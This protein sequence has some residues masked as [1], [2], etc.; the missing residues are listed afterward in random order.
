MQF[1]R[2]IYKTPPGTHEGALVKLKRKFKEWWL[3]PVIYRELTRGGDNTALKQWAANHLW[4]AQR[5]GG[6]PLHGV[7]LTSRVVF[8]KEAKDLSIAEQFVLAS[9]VNKPDHPAGRQRAA[10]RG[11]ARPLALHHRG[12]RAHLRR[13]ADRGRGAAEAGGV[14]A[15]Q[16]GGGPARPEGQAE[17][18][19]GARQ[20][21]RRRSPSARAGQS[22]HPRQRAD[23]GGPLRH[24]RGDEAGLRLRLARARARR[25]D[26]A[27]RGGEPGVRRAHRQRLAEIDAK[28]ADKIGAGFTLDPGQDHRRTTERPTSS[29]SPPTPRA[30]SCATSRRARRRPTSA[31]RSRASRR[32]ATTTA[33]AKAA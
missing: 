12:A 9:A 30:R 11:A 21:T 13:E 18:A 16:P 28:H 1:V 17:A 27:R 15:R 6:S 7:E 29:S 25:H 2:V 22:G 26:D 20:A 19:G 24:A 14:R 3:A 32:P 8:G 33:A 10:Q 5:T 23:A 31:R 4:L